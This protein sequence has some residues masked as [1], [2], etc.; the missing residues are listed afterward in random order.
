MSTW[1]NN[2]TDEVLPA[3]QSFAVVG[4]MPE[5]LRLAYERQQQAGDRGEPAGRSRRH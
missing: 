4:P 1:R 2:L 5:A 3:A